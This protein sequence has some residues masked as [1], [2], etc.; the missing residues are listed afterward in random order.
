MPD[1]HDELGLEQAAVEL[2]SVLAALYR[3][4]RQTKELGELTGPESAAISRLAQQGSM[5]AAELAKLERISP[6]SM[7]T[8]LQG[9]RAKGLVQRSADPDDGRRLILSLTTAG[10]D[11]IRD[12][13]AV[14]TAQ[15]TEALAAL[16]PDER[17]RLL[18]ALP[19][20]TRLAREL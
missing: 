2:R 1:D 8:T 6:Q 4:I 5:T 12:R 16:E 11:T 19:A 3:R 13:R 7:A 14:R 9:L 15:F 20:L 17:E 10:Q 18:A